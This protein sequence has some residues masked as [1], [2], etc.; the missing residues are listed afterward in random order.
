MSLS[1]ALVQ[2]V[3]AQADVAVDKLRAQV[4]EAV[5]GVLASVAVRVVEGPTEGGAE[6]ERRGRGSA[7]CRSHHELRQRLLLALPLSEALRTLLVAL[8]AHL[9]ALLLD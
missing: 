9:V 6:R 2:R 5:A 1:G 3:L 4:A 8:L 7:R